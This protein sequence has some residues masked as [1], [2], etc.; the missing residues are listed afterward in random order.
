MKVNSIAALAVLGFMA[1]AANLIGALTFLALKMYRLH[2]VL[3]VTMYTRSY[4]SA[5]QVYYG[6][7]TLL[8][9]IVQLALGGY[10]QNKL[11]SGL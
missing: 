7:L 8:A 4:Y 6:I 2:T 11:K 9:G 10:V 1:Y 5:R 3:G